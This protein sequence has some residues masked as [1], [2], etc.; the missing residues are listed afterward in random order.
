M[1]NIVLSLLP[2]SYLSIQPE[3]KALRVSLAVSVNWREGTVLLEL[4]PSFLLGCLFKII[5]YL[6]SSNDLLPSDKDYSGNN[7]FI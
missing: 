3:A 1:D 4:S 2:S 5:E 7:L 6:K